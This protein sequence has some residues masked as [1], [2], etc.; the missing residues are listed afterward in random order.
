MGIA[1]LVFV[2][3]AFAMF[4]SVASAAELHVGPGQTYSTIQSAVNAASAGDTIIVHDG[5]YNEN[6][7]VD[8]A[9]LTIQSQNGSANCIVQGTLDDHVFYIGYNKDYVNLSGFTIKG[10]AGSTKAGIYPDHGDYCNI[11]NNDISANRY[12][13]QLRYTTHSTFSDNTANSNTHVG[14]YLAWG[15]TDNEITGNT[16]NS[17]TN[18]GIYIETTEPSSNNISCNYIYNNLTSTQL[19]FL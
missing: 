1:I 14:I 17:N 8:V 2:V 10:A 5:T 19:L 13:I 6:V 15:D 18:H 4:T 12:G 7:D 16:F 11:S 9:H 3:S